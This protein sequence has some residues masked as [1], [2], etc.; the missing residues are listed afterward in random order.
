MQR[1]NS[2]STELELEGMRYYYRMYP[3]GTLRI[4]GRQLPAFRRDH[5]YY[6][7]ARGSEPVAPI[8]FVSGAWQQMEGWMRHAEY[9][10]R[11]APVILLDP[12]GNG[13]ADAAPAHY[14]LE[15]FESAMLQ[16][17]DAERVSRINLL[18]FS[19]GTALAFGLAQSHPER[20]ERVALV[21]TMAGIS[22]AVR[23]TLRRAI[24]A[25]HCR[26]ADDFADAVLTSL[27]CKDADIPNRRLVH[28]LVRASL[29]RLTPQD[30]WKYE[31]N[32]MRLLIHPPLDVSRSLDAPTLVLTGEHDI[33]T[34]PARGRELARACTRA[35]FTTIRHAGH[36]SHLENPRALMELTLNFFREL[37]LDG[38]PDCAPIE[39]FGCDLADLRKVA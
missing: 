9:A 26:Q 2:E 31:Q 33:F 22:D 19:Y 1:P 6:C 16:V 28:R 39:Y 3:V 30:Y 24:R 4:P 14:G 37:P 38:V 17:L 23:E 34:P 7:S 12:P 29:T 8:L 35:A 13:T 25:L 11:L 36:F 21:G 5:D 27:A 15:F 32:A 18:G 10:N 20:V